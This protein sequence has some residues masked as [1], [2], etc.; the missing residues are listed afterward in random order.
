M[1]KTRDRILSAL[2]HHQFKKHKDVLLQRICN[3]I[4]NLE[5]TDYLDR[6]RRGEEEHGVITDEVIQEMD[7]DRELEEEIKDAFWYHVMSHVKNEQNNN[8]K[9]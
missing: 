9:K 5:P 3:I 4:R 6:W 1:N 8:G 7:F 2:E